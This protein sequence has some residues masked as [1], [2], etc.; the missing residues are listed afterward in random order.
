[1][2]GTVAVFGASGRIGQAQVRQL[3]SSGYPTIAVTR[4][5]SIFRDRAYNGV[6]VESADY[7]VPASLDRALEGVSAVFFQRP[8]FGSPT[9]ASQQAQNVLN[10]ALRAGV[11]RFILNSTM[12]APDDTP[13]GQPLYDDVR[14][15]EDR[16][17]A[18]GLPLVVFRPV[19]FLDNL[20]TQFAKP[21]IVDEGIYRYCHR[22]GLEANWICMDD[23][24][25]FMIAGL[26]RS[27]LVG[28][29]FT[30]GGPERLRIEHVLAIL[31]DVVGRSV[32]LEYLPGRQFG[33]YIYER[34]GSALGPDKKAIADFWDSFYT[35][36]NYSSR[37]P[38]EVDMEALMKAIPMDLTPMRV[39]ARR[40]DWKTSQPGETG[41]I[42][43]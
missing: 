25:R 14:A 42:A 10:A 20:L 23:V 43:G 32:T 8:S 17:A 41:S 19:L 27:D 39:W 12:W 31:S 34:L 13:C 1:M 29:R 15:V 11:T 28:G 22:P 2:K 36:N 40:Q 7:D 16:F 5:A 24:A 30:I 35:F 6:R 33:E 26:E 38:F 4:H 3:L 18:S 37:R 9:Q 21:P